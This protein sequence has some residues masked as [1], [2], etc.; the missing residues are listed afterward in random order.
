MKIAQLPLESVVTGT[1]YLQANRDVDTILAVGRLNTSFKG[2][3]KDFKK[4]LSIPPTLKE[5]VKL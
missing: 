5:P 1:I 4:H 3:K 2:L